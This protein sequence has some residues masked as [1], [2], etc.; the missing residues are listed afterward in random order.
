MP[1]SFAASMMASEANVDPP[2]AAPTPQL[3]KT[4]YV[5]DLPTGIT[6]DF[7]FQLMG[8]VGPVEDIV[9]RKGRKDRRGHDICSAFVT[10]GDHKT[11]ERALQELNYIKLD[12]V[13]I[14]MR[15]WDE[16]TNRIRKS[17]Q[18]CL[19]L[20]NL[21]KS[22]EA[23]QLHE[24]LANFGEI[25][26]C[27]IETGMDH[28]SLGCSLV[29]FRRVEDAEQAVND[30]KDAAINGI[31]V[32]V[33]PYLEIK[34]S[35]RKVY[36]R[37][38]PKTVVDR[39]SFLEFLGRFYPAIFGDIDY[40][41]DY[42]QPRLVLDEDGVSTGS[43]FCVMKGLREALDLTEALEDHFIEAEMFTGS[44]EMRK[45]APQ[46][47][48]QWRQPKYRDCNLYV[49]GFDEDFT[50]EELREKFSGFGKIESVMIMFDAC[51]RSKKFG[52]VC[53]VDQ[54]SA[55]RALAGSVFIQFG[56]SEA[57]CAIARSAGERKKRNMERSRNKRQATFPV[58]QEGQPFGDPEA[59]FG[60]QPF[61]FADPGTDFPGGLFGSSAMPAA[62]PSDRDMIE[63]E[64]IKKCGA[65]GQALLRRLRD[66]SDDQCESLTQ[67]EAML[68][69][70]IDTNKYRY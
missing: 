52:F 5:T 23:S 48:E 16:E 65:Q 10:F 25:I 33:E 42:P 14:H 28:M 12:G 20:K 15:W 46:K 32:H 3:S 1:M 39:E 36:I 17:K 57:Y 11:A 22:I 24:A 64:I 51:G 13:P 53:F 2:L 60:G 59:D 45:K 69:E 62:L 54:M 43:G 49:R 40:T 35:D 47:L 68:I 26:S 7:L 19:F 63:A 34:E 67:N 8:E 6:R 58:P 50:E 41:C 70:W 18:G 4:L 29:Q 44:E 61:G 30:L 66:L 9:L 56:D 55:Q 31:P 38:L 21:D 37:G 27:K